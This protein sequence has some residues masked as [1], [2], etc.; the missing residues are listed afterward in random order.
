MFLG[1][2]D[3]CPMLCGLP[4]EEV[5]RKCPG[6]VEEVTEILERADLVR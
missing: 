1:T 6:M 3:T 4:E 2:T 5:E